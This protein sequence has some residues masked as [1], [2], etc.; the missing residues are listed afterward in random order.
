MSDSTAFRRVS[1]RDVSQP[2]VV[3]AALS[4][5]MLERGVTADTPAT[6]RVELRW[7]GEEEEEEE[8]VTLKGRPLQLPAVDDTSDP[9]IVLVRP[10]SFDRDE[11]RPEC[12]RVDKDPGEGFGR[13][14]GLWVDEVERGDEFACEAEVW[15]DH[16]AEGC[17]PPGRYVFEDRTYVDEWD[18]LAEWSFELEVTAS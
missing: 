11:A 7:T 18:A 3:P 10:G 12:W 6:I 13:G 1:V 2:T 5:A 15:T 4:V 9:T 16:R 17:L 8:E 14:L